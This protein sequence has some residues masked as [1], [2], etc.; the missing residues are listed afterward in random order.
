MYSLGHLQYL[1]LELI[2]DILGPVER[3]EIVWKI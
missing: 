3:I 2:L 1:N